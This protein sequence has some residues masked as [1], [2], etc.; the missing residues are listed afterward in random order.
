MMDLAVDAD[1]D[2]VILS[3]GEGTTRDYLE[4]ASS[5]LNVRK[6]GRTHPANVNLQEIIGAIGGRL[7]SKLSR[8]HKPGQQRNGLNK[9]TTKT[10]Q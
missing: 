10:V 6:W 4:R 2:V 8:M 9:V 3:T 5:T 1:V 7:C